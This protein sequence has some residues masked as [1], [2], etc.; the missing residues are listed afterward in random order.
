[1]IE[2]K[3]DVPK[4]KGHISQEQEQHAS[5]GSLEQIRTTICQ[6][7]TIARV[8]TFPEVTFGALIAD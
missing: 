7:R 2:D 1:M 4:K 8:G 3:E 5:Q 6:S